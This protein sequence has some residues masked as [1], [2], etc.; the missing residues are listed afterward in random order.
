MAATSGTYNF[1]SVEVETLIRD[2]YENIGIEPEF[3]TPQKLDSARRSINLLLLEWINKSTNL[4]TLQSDFLLINEFQTKY[5]L[6]NYVSDLT[7]VNLRTSSRQLDGTAASSSGGVAAN[8]FDA[9]KETACTQTA[10]NGNISYDYGEGVTQT[11]DFF[12]IIAN[13][14]EDYTLAVEVSNDNVNW[15]NILTIEKQSYVKGNLYWFD[16]FAPM[17]ARYY[18]VR[19]SGGATL[20]IQELYF[21]NNILDTTISSLSRNEYLQ[22][23]QKNITGRPSVYYFDRTIEPSISI[24]PSPSSIY[25]VISYS[26]IKLMQDVGL[27]SNAIEI[28]SRFYPALVTGL[29]FKLAL[30]FNNQVAEIFNSEYQDSFNLASIEDS[31]INTISIRPSWNSSG[32]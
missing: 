1:Q 8:A 27:Y 26:Y 3:I 24:W 32:Q 13:A 19:E 20:D 15:Y 31:E 6:E 22:L 12:G 2:A 16:I 5:I 29:S 14:T 28:P 18:R 4:W 30:K 25:N 9:N 7:E 10:A 11:I 21:N 17:N 23:P